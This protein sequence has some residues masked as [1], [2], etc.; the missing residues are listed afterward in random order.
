MLDIEVSEL[1]DL[2]VADSSVERC[3]ETHSETARTPLSDG[4]CNSASLNAESIVG[5]EPSYQGLNSSDEREVARICPLSDGGCNSASL[6]VGSDI[7]SRIEQKVEES[8][9][10][11]NVSDDGCNST[12]LNADNDIV[13]KCL[14]I[15]NETLLMHVQWHGKNHRV[16]AAAIAPH[17]MW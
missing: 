3:S 12:S 4:G 7:G 14:G 13:A 9:N 5:L 6:D 15:K 8:P 10:L 1:I 16:T 11:E 2:N 17:S